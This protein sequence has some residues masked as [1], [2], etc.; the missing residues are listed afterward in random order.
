MGH[1]EQSGLVR[2]VNLP[3]A[4]NAQDTVTSR[5]AALVLVGQEGCNGEAETT[6]DEEPGASYN[7]TILVTVDETGGA[8][9]PTCHDVQCTESPGMTQPLVDETKGQR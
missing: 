9:P 3:W 2:R 6:R 7:E 4:T 5:S 1:E 8:R